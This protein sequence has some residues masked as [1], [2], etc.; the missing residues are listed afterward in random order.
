M[1][2]KKIAYIIGAGPAGL[3]AAYELL[4]RTD[5]KPIIIEESQEIGGLSRTVDFEGNKIDIGGH[6]FFSKSDRVND[7][8]RKVLPVQNA[9]SI[10]ELLLKFDTTEK[11]KDYI[12]GAN[13]EST[14][15]V[16]LIRG[17]ISRIFFL[18]KFFQYPISL[19][20]ST[21]KNLG[22]LN[23]FK[24]GFSYL[25]TRLFPIKSEKSLE[26]FFINR[27]GKVLYEMFFKDYTH[28]VWGIPCSSISPE[29]G[30]QRVKG[31][32]ISKTI[33]H[34]FK[35]L[36]HVANSKNQKKVETSLIERFFYP[37]FG[38]GQLWEEVANIIV[39]KGGEI[40]K[41]EKVVS[42]EIDKETNNIVSLTT[43][44]DKTYT[45]DLF[46][47]SMPVKDL[48]ESFKSSCPDY[49]KEISR[50]LLYRDF[51]TVGLLVDKLKIKNTT[52]IPTLNN[53]VPDNWIYIQEKNVT[54]ARLQIFNNWSPYMVKDTNT[55][56]I[57]MEFLCSEGDNL[58][59]MDNEKFIELAIN[60][61][62][63][64]NII[65]KNDVIKSHIIRVKKAYPA[66]FGTYD[67]FDVVKNFLNGVDNLFLIGR[68][69][70][71]R[72]NNMD[73]SMLTAMVAVDNIASN[74]KSKEN[75]WSVN[76]EDEY[77]E[78][79]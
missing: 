8:W 69:G 62:S 58:W 42:L 75:I 13:P 72:Y 30:A 52:N 39:S 10:D 36:L 51:I 37:K 44:A 23:V 22:V 56:W 47:S 9:P 41:G 45:G 29:W 64:I 55:A 34:A 26:D 71:H 68:N 67:K 28:K 27:F 2:S 66:Y 48:I 38:P 12:N 19:S 5:F 31:L 57:G 21:L 79:K 77:H 61:L 7:L 25:Y 53:I 49:V 24:I 74:I 16:M 15:K 32:S 20:I 35:K 1:S 59:N 43:T 54:V 6:R 50:G 40:I 65:N 46:F 11:Y 14:D 18:N 33:L 70:L 3:T 60:E 76:T 73:H 63:K 78:T 4:T 17:R